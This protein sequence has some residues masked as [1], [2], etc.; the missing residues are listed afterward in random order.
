MLMFMT[1]ASA[2]PSDEELSLFKSG[3]AISAPWRASTYNSALKL[4][5]VPG[6]VVNHVS[7]RCT[8]SKGG[9]SLRGSLS[10]SGLLARD[11]NKNKDMS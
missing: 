2:L 11:H 5:V 4:K 1:S 8:R 10:R 6:F 9:R 3:D 7:L